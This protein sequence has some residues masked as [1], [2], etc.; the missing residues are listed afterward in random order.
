MPL[1]LPIHGFAHIGVVR[2]KLEYPPYPCAV[3]ARMIEEVIRVCEIC[4]KA[5]QISRLGFLGQPCPDLRAPDAQVV[6]C[7]P[8]PKIKKGVVGNG[9]Q[10]GATTVSGCNTAA[11]KQFLTRFIQRVVMHC[12][13]LQ[14][15][16]KASQV[17]V[18]LAYLILANIHQPSP[19]HQTIVWQALQPGCSQRHFTQ[20]AQP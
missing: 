19:G 16:A 11:G 2:A 13:S 6:I 4:Q 15:I 17:P 12:D 14:S 7:V 1:G 20:V 8:H 18:H 10:V 9:V 3:V 5:K